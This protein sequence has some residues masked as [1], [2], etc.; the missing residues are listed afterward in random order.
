VIGELLDSV[1][2]GPIEPLVGF[3][4]VGIGGAIASIYY[5]AWWFLIPCLV[6][7]ALAGKSLFRRARKVY[8]EGSWQPS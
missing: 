2:M 7:A 6:V 3:L 5:G 4:V 8:R 1:T